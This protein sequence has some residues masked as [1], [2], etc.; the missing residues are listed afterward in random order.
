VCFGNG[1]A[2][3]SFYPEKLFP[4]AIA[5][6]VSGGNAPGARDLVKQVVSTEAFQHRLEHL[7]GDDRKDYGKVMGALNPTNRKD[8]IQPLLDNSKINWGHMALARL[9]RQTNVQR[10]LTFN[11]DLV[12]ER[13]ASLMGMHLPVYDFGVAPTKDISGLATPAIYHLHGQSYG[14]RLMN[15][16]QET[17]DH[18]NRLRAV[19]ADSLRHH[20]TLVTGYG[21]AADG[22]FKV[23][24]V[25][26]NSQND[27][28]WL[29]YGKTPDRHLKPL[30]DKEYA[31][32]IGGCDFDTTMI[33]LARE[34]GC[35]PPEVIANPPAHV[36]EELEDVV[37]YPVQPETGLDIL[38]D[39]RKR[40]KNAA[41]VL[42]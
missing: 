13:S 12:L 23:M 37:D 17:Q 5:A 38:T 20:T 2:T 22:A 27:L 32:Y 25:E 36:L 24:E 1:A 42:G 4:A 8:L 35:F 10:I 30:L 16:A 31:N 7:K 18:A 14:L 41:G 11:F 21:G 39:T 29:G 9:I 19:I 33:T 28:F 34:L 15:S 3:S 6:W 40:L 26:F